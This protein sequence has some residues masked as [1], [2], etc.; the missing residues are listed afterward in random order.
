MHCKA[1]NTRIS[2][3]TRTCPHCGHAQPQARFSDQSARSQPTDDPADSHSR[4][5][6]SSFTTSAVPEVADMDVD[7]DDE[8]ELPLEDAM[9]MGGDDSLRSGA[10]P[11]P[12]SVPA[13]KP[14]AAA[15]AKPVPARSERRRSGGDRRVGSAGRRESDQSAEAGSSAVAGMAIDAEQLRH[16]IGEQPDL[17]ESG[18]RV[19]G[20]EGRRQVGI[21]YGTEVGE[22]DLLARSES[23]DWVIVMV[24]GDDDGST[25]VSDVLHRVGWVRKHLAEPG[26]RVR[27]ILLLD[28]V[29]EALGYAAA[30]VSDTIS[31]RTWRVSIQFEPVDV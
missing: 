9:A 29:D 28:R 1:C 12:S 15:V 3:T 31:F 16:L 8:V 25:L 11:A 14:A 20:E 17:L 21:G 10:R 30:A 26:D 4:L 19:L 24:A 23:G 18:L 6:P 5:S 2:S 22:I 7:L 13:S 27:A